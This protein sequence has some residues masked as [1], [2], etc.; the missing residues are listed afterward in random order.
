MNLITSFTFRIFKRL[1]SFLR[2]PGPSGPA[3]RL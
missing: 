2:L 3:V 1:T